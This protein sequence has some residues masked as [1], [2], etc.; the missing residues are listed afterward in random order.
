M[1][2]PQIDAAE[3]NEKPSGSSEQ[4]SLVDASSHSTQS[5]N[6]HATRDQEGVPATGNEPLIKK[7]VLSSSR[8]SRELNGYTRDE[9]V[10]PAQGIYYCIKNI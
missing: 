5:L 9:S 3:Q 1:Y 4:P 7:Q 6:Q 10:E 2:P 8:G